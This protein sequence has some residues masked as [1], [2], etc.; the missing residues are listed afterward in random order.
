MLILMVVPPKVQ[1]HAYGHWQSACVRG[2]YN[3][4]STIYSLGQMNFNLFLS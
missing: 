4:T 1:L 3:M 2:D